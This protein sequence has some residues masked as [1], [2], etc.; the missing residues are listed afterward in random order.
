MRDV[1]PDDRPVELTPERAREYVL[2]LG[3][4][5]A[6]GEIAISPL[7]GG[8]SNLV[9]LAETDERRYVLKQPRPNLAVEDDWPASVSRVHNEA[10]AMRTYDRLL[11]RRSVGSRIRSAGSRLRSVSSRVRVPQV[12]HEDETNHVVVME[13]APP[14]ATMW[15]EELLSGSVD[16]TIS[17]VLGAV[18]GTV[19]AETADDPS[20]AASFSDRTPFRQLRLEPYHETTARRHPDVAET[21]FA[22]ARRLEETERTLVHGDFS[23]KNVLVDRNG[24][25]VELW[26][27]DFEVCHWGDPAFDSAFMLN[28]LL[29]KS[30]F[31]R[32]SVEEFHESARAFWN[33]YDEVAPWDVETETVRELGVLMLARVDGKSPV[34]YVTTEPVADALR[35]IAKT[36]LRSE[37]T[38]IEAVFEVVSEA[39]DSL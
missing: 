25:E 1:A 35:S 14:S 17:P 6:G 36:L 19:H 5:S 21:I 28:H 37:A 26:L 4:V 38:E 15:K 34:E 23:P 2:E 33:T 30:V 24:P 12:L 20:I 13:A 29:I 39:V 3:G 7:G 18:L 10:R 22:E 31:N 9:Y 16:P 27:L 32:E 8:V 11:D